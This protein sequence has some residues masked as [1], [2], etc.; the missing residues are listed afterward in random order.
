MNLARCCFSILLKLVKVA[1]FEP[2]IPA[3]KAGALGH[4]K[5]HPENKSPGARTI[6]LTGFQ[7][8]EE[9]EETTPGSIPA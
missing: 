6:A 2:A 8:P 4:A 1:G 9:E 3:P 5:L 7:L